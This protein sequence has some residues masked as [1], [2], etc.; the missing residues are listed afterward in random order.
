M[1]ILNLLFDKGYL[2]QSDEPG[3][4]LRCA[5]AT[6]QYQ[7]WNADIRP[8]QKE[9]RAP[10]GMIFAKECNQKGAEVLFDR[11]RKNWNELNYDPEVLILNTSECNLNCPYC[12]V[13]V[14]KASKFNL[15]TTQQ[16]ENAFRLFPVRR[17]V[18]TGGEPLVEK[19]KFCE[20]LEWLIGRIERCDVITN[21]LEW[22]GTL[23]PLL[24]KCGKKFDLWMRLTL[25]ENLSHMKLSEFENK[26]LP[27][28]RDISEVKINLNFLP[29][30]DGS[31]LVRFL[32]RV[33]QLELPSHITVTP[34][35]LTESKVSGPV[36]FNIENYLLE[37][38]EVVENEGEFLSKVNFDPGK[39]LW[40]LV[41]DLQLLGC[42]RRTVTLSDKGY[43]L[44]NI[45]HCEGKV[46][47][48]PLEAASFI[49]ERLVRVCR[50][51]EHYPDNC[52]EA[53]K[54]DKCPRFE[55]GCN[56][57]PII[58]ICALRCP[59]AFD[60]EKDLCVGE[61]DLQCLGYPLLR[62]FANWL[63]HRNRTWKEIQGE[64]TTMQT[65]TSQG[66]EIR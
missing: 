27:K 7:T 63:M 57:C 10:F 17:V 12:I 22:D 14:E 48:G 2:F 3:L 64:V 53:I 34:S 15:P 55:L 66:D 38:I 35:Y 21:G 5:D 43:A 37:M 46:F 18:I 44:C 58:Y 20:I 40:L 61:T 16:I 33:N 30:H 24:L 8:T 1:D 13:G 31:G 42:K 26:I 11:L 39:S 36:E 32:R 28:A 54:S 4:F 56:R 6:L 59:Y 19:E 65:G 45:F 62:I 49:W 52:I 41:H 47:K 60:V 9:T 50:D 29:N 25:S 51:C 23:W